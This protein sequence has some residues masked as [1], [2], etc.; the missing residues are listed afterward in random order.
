LFE[1]GEDIAAVELDNHQIRNFLGQPAQV[2]AC[3]GRHDMDSLATQLRQAGQGQ[4]GFVLQQDIAGLKIGGVFTRSG[5]DPA[6][7]SRSPGDNRC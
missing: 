1:Q 3:R 2:S 5:A 7:A 6:K 4:G